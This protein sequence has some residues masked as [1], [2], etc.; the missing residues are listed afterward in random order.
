MLEIDAVEK[1]LR[2]LIRKKGVNYSAFAREIGMNGH[3]FNSLLNG[4]SKPSLSTL[5]KIANS[6]NVSLDW[7]CTEEEE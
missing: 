6:Q 1:R 5:I 7:L 4:V 3:A 2:E